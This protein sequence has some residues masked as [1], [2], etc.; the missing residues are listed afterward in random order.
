[1]ASELTLA[2]IRSIEDF[3]LSSARFQLPQ[4]RDFEK[5]NKRIIANL[6][7]YQT[8]YFLMAIILFTL[9]GYLLYVLKISFFH[10]FL[11][12]LYRFFF[13]TISFVFENF[14]SNR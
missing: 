10:Q 14:F 2:P 9:I 12:F 3:L 11:L 4:F 6:L 8:N 7:Y 13:S 5:W 1:M